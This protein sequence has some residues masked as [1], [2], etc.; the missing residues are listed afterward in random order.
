MLVTTFDVAITFFQACF[1]FAIGIFLRQKF[2]GCCLFKYSCEIVYFQILILQT[3]TL[4]GS[5]SVCRK[6]QS[7]HLS[8]QNRQMTCNISQCFVNSSVVLFYLLTVILSFTLL[9]CILC[10]FLVIHSLQNSI[11]ILTVRLVKYSLHYY[12]GYA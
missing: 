11:S 9:L 12:T 5:V 1:V 6:Y 3:A 2:L 7:A 10:I 8:C 4:L